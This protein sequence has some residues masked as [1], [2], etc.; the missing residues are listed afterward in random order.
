MKIEAITRV[1]DLLDENPNFCKVVRLISGCG[2]DVTIEV[3]DENIMFRIPDD[4]SLTG[5]EIDDLHDLGC[6]FF[7]GARIT[8]DA[9]WTM[10]RHSDRNIERR[11]HEAAKWFNGVLEECFPSTPEGVA[12]AESRLPDVDL[13]ESLK[14]SAKVLERIQEM[15]RRRCPKCGASTLATFTSDLDWCPV[16]KE[17]FP[18]R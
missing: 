11:L 8:K 17:T 5:D 15:A 14:D 4:S 2:D 3:N 13:P 9:I 10:R 1:L 18:G 12:A 7:R 6:V 16:C